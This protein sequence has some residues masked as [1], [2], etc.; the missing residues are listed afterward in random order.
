MS[1]VLVTETVAEAGIELLREH[2]EVDITTNLAAADL[3]GVVGGYDALLVRSRTRV[4]E[5]VLA[6]AG[7]LL[8]VG[9]VGTGVDNIDLAAATRRGIAVVNA[10]YGNTFSV[11]E[12]TI[13]MMLALARRIPQA[14]AALRQGRWEKQRCEGVQVRGKVLGL[15]GL[16][17]V[18]TAVARRALGL[19]MQVL[20]YDPFVTPDRAS[21]VGVQWVPWEELLRRSDFLSLHLPDGEQTR[22]LLGAREL[23]LMKA[24]ACV[25]NCARG[26]LVDEAALVRAL[27]EQEIGGAALDVFA[28]EPL[29]CSSPLLQCNRVVL[30]PHLAG[31]TAEAQRDTAVEVARQVLDVLEGRVPRYPVNAPALSPDELDEV[32][33]YLDLAQRLGS[34]YAQFG[35]NHLQSLELACSGEI[36]RQRLDLILSAAL[37]GLLRAASEEPV[38]WINAQVMAQERGIGLA[39][40]LEPPS[41]TSG[42]ANLVELRLCSES[43][44]HV[45]AGAVLRSEPHIVQVDGFGL[46]FVAKGL[47]LV[48]EHVEQPG[49]LGRMGTVLGDAGVNIHFVQVGREQRG[50]PGLL[51]M[52]LDD[53]PSPEVLAQVLAL[54]SI[55]SAKMVKL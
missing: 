7:R 40:R 47:L 8:V 15:A 4:T 5:E 13:A 54:P 27:R 37:V 44:Q 22:G 34:F 14:D 42:W 6:A 18:G 30:T 41:S 26:R 53:S 20:A 55:R 28:E 16:G 21:Q 3:V 32:G 43:R 31:S 52:G 10:P 39:T 36:G 12:H 19:E 2:A 1:K 46:D 11:A 38:N 25:I 33:P 49:I 35:G 29:S 24:S 45:L 48:S 17:R 50:G 9:R 23:A 51:L